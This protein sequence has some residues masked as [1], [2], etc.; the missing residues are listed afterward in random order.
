MKGGNQPRGC[1]YTVIE[2]LI[3]LAISGAMFAIA[4][5]F[6]N[7]RRERSTFTAGVSEMASR[8][9]DT[10]EQVTDGQY[11]DVSIN[12]T[13]AAGVTTIVGGGVGQGTNPGCVF[14]GKVL[15]FAENSSG[16][17]TWPAS[18]DG[19]HYEIFSIAG[20]RQNAGVPVTALTGPTGADPTVIDVLTKQQIISQ[21]L[22]I[23]KV[24]V[25]GVGGTNHFGIGFFQ[26]QGGLDVNGN[27][28]NGAQPVKLY[29]L[30]GVSASAMSS[31][32]VGQV[33]LGPGSNLLPVTGK[34][35]ICLTD[36]EQYANLEIGTNNN[37]LTVK[38]IRYGSV[39]SCI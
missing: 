10:I 19:A 37:L 32:A 3:V 22:L 21:S 6:I 36:G 12:C 9:Q 39:A 24:T 8:I 29:Y 23:T 25:S 1:G 34:V 28:N 4:A 11:S 31:T 38:T 30:N 5:Q 17:G 15:H 18:E 33:N 14:L 16:V 7:G 35:D 13:F 26:G 2:V 27:F 20:G